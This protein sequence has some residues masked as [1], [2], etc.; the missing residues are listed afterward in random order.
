MMI[1]V[2]C[3]WPVA[4]MI[5]V[6]FG[7]AFWLF[8]VMKERKH[9]LVAV[10]ILGTEERRVAAGFVGQQNREGRRGRVGD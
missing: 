6:D 10:M 4:V 3:S 2:G 7:N 5:L 8:A 9:R 1:L